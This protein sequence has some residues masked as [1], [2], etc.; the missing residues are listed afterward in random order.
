MQSLNVDK[1]L[2]YWDRQVSSFDAIYTGEKPTWRRFLDRVLRRDM[3]RRFDWVLQNSK[4]L[5]GKSVCDLGCGSGR[6]VVAYAESG[7]RRVV[8]IDGAPGMVQQT[9]SLIRGRQLHDRATVWEANI[10]DCPNDETFDITLAVGVF[11]Y[12][13]NAHPY[14]QRIITNTRARVLA[15]F[16]R[17]WTYRMPIRKTRLGVLGCPVYFYTA[18]QVGALLKEAG[19]HCE[20]LERVGAIYCVL[21]FP[22][23][24]PPRAN[25]VARCPSGVSKKLPS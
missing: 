16:P 7:A 12:T 8:G 4:D 22:V 5:A 14:F 20:L 21:A 24:P 1:T 6:Y 13:A 11:D 10:L 19:F 3:Y 15:T 9:A 17:F 18:K 25:S 23:H 2:S